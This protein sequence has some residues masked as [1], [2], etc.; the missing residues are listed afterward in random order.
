MNRCIIICI[1]SLLSLFKVKGQSALNDIPLTLQKLYS[2]ILNADDDERIRLNDSVRLII[3]DYAISDSVFRH[4][5][6]NLRYLGQIDSPDKKL[7]FITWNLPLRNGENRYYL[8]ILRKN[9]RRGENTVYKLEGKYRQGT[10]STDKTYSAG[11]WYG[12]LYYAIQ[13]FR[14]KGKKHYLLLGLDSD[15]INNSRK[16]IDILDFNE[17]DEIIF[18]QDCLIKDAKKKYREVLE[19]SAEGMISL[20]LRTKKLIVFDHID[21]FAM[22][23]ENDPESFGAGLSFDGYSFRKGNWEFVSDI[24][25]RNLK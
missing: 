25:V 23:H 15:N 24:D 1:F 16:I 17:K 14:Y 18:G 5:F 11:D 12:A 6:D 19:Y 21:P 10:I 22:G 9:K 4:R 3:N 13:P 2:A 8:Y 7:K 20:R